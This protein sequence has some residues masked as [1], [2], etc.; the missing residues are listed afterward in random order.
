MFYNG[1]S[2]N[3]NVDIVS[4]DV[5]LYSGIPK[6]FYALKDKQFNDWE[7][8][9]W[10]LFIFKDT[11]LGEGSFS[12]VYLAKW[13]E[14][15]V[16]AKVIDRKFLQ[17]KKEIVMREIDIMSKLHHPNVVQFLGYID[18]PFTI[19]LEYIPSGDL[20]A[21]IKKLNKKQKLSIMRD[22][23]KGLA[24]IHNRRPNNLIHHL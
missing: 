11:L 23:L 13:R 21:N 9:P 16:V 4:T 10:E 3:Y 15:F 20:S 14:T 17:I 2:K 22:I 18:D 1:L 19:V 8:P 7:I 5:S 6:D 24:Y 12:K